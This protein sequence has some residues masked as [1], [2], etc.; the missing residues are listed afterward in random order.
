MR[1]RRYLQATA[2]VVTGGLAGCSDL[3]MGGDETSTP[4][5]TPTA[6]EEPTPREEPRNVDPP[7]WLKLLARDHLDNAGEYS[8]MSVFQRVDWEWYLGMRST[9]PVWGPA[10]DQIWSFKPTRANAKIVPSAD[11]LKTPQWGAWIAAL[12]V[13]GGVFRLP[14]LGP[15]MER[16]CGLAAEEGEREAARVVDDVVTYNTPNV[17]IFVGA[18]TDAVH[19]A[20]TDNKG[21]E[22]SNAPVTRYFGYEDAASRNIYVSEAWSRGV[23]AVETGD[24]EGEDLLPLLQRVA[25]GHEGVAAEASVRWCLGQAVT[26]APVVTGEVNGSRYQFAEQGRADRGVE[27]LEPFDTLITIL[28]ARQFTGTVQ[29]VFSRTDGEA[30]G[31]GELRESFELESG[32]W[33]TAY[34][35]SVSTIDATW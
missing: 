7:L 28:D 23:V 35:P 29:H 14:N 24:E 32:T 18:D 20:L 5:E 13:E 21:T 15:E 11:I 33:S 1:R 10:G 34:H 9:L 26:G 6:T 2:T 3:G 4:T 27:R 17:T 25:G 19:E 16:Q 12:N 22:F 31:S 8:D 30:P